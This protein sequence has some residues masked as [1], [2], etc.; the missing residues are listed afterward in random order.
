MILLV[1]LLI[2]L[3]SI[4]TPVAN[5]GESFVSGTPQNANLHTNS[6]KE[7][8]V[9]DSLTSLTFNNHTHYLGLDN[10]NCF[11]I[12]ADSLYYA[13][14]TAI[15]NY[16]LNTKETLKVVDVTD[17]ED[18]TYS[19]NTLY[20]FK[21]N[22]LYRFNNGSLTKMFDCDMY[23]TYSTDNSTF[24]TYISGNTFNAIRITENEE[25]PTSIWS[26]SIGNTLTPVSITNNETTAFLVAHQNGYKILEINF[27]EEIT[28]TFNYSF[29][30]NKVHYLKQTATTPILVCY[31]D[32]IF[33]V[34]LK[35]EDDSNRYTQ[36]ES[37]ELQGHD[38]FS[39]VENT[40]YK[41]KDCYV[42]NN[43]LYVLDNVY[44][45]IQMFDYNTEIEFKQVVTSS[46]AYTDG[47]F[48]NPN[49]FNVVNKNT[50][51]VADTYNKAIQV[52][53]NNN[54]TLV[55]SYTNNQNKVN[56]DYVLRAIKTNTNY[57]VLQ[58]DDLDNYEILVLDAKFNLINSINHSLTSILD[59]ALIS[60][61]LYIV[62][63]NTTTLYRY[64]NNIL[65]PT[66]LTSLQLSTNSKCHYILETNSLAITNNND[67]H[68]IDIGKQV[69]NTYS[70]TENVLSVA[71]DFKG[72]AYLLTANNIIRINSAD[73]T[74]ETT[75]AII[76]ISKNYSHID[77]EKETGDIYLFDSTN[78]CFETLKST[79][80]YSLQSDYLHP[81]NINTYISSDIVKIATTGNNV[82]CYTYPYNAGL[83]YEISNK[84]VYILDEN[85]IPGY[86]YIAYRFETADNYS[87]LGLGY[88]SKH[89]ANIKKV[90]QVATLLDSY[91]VLTNTT[92]YALP[93][94]LKY[95]NENLVI[96]ELTKNTTVKTGF[97]L[98]SGDKFSID[99]CDYYAIATE[100][101]IGYIKKVDV[102]SSKV[103]KT[104]EIL[105]SNAKLAVS[106][107]NY[108]AVYVYAGNNSFVVDKLIVGKEVYVEKYDM[109]EKYTYIRYLDENNREHSGYVLTK[110]IK[111]NDTAK[112]NLGAIILII[113]TSIAVCGITTF[114]VI[115]YKKQQKNIE[116]T[117]D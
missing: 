107:D 41:I 33:R 28:E 25:T 103:N 45:A 80:S 46:S 57:Y 24:I 30:I 20:I 13:T 52:V 85:T 111:M 76:T 4:L 104:E 82:Y 14:D 44:S 87:S 117:K 10:A 29:T 61:D 68:F 96:G 64:T 99:G 65:E 92:I 93:T 26:T 50:F 38:E 90:N 109:N 39:F 55:K 21:T 18:I 79:K 115:S 37:M 17:V 7:A 11:S 73:L 54:A 3:I 16:N 113:F 70:N 102:V 9:V 105:K 60:N 2:S 83:S 58:K 23:S 78:Q 101:G 6:V 12:T 31:T 66:T 8:T 34:V 19:N 36:D 47:K 112:S 71:G 95:N 94:M 89:N 84:N 67:V 77:I 35:R 40:F 110:C 63:Y 15:F 27:S 100:Q 116:T 59:I 62:D 98:I 22:S 86:W 56:F 5:S 81:A 53:E 51:V 32:D 72:N 88:I 1:G 91:T 108:N 49:S 106:E 69:L 74:N 43:N 97:E 42:Y 75:K 114:Y 48:Y